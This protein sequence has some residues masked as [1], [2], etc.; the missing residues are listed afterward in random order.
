MF[1]RIGRSDTLRHEVVEYIR[2]LIEEGKLKPGDRLP[3][4]R[5]MAEKFGVSRTVI[6]DAVKTLTGLGVLEVK[7]GIGIFAAVPDSQSIARQ[8]SGLLFYRE[9]TIN[10]LFEVRMLLETEAAGWAAER[11]NREDLELL[12]E[13][14]RSHKSIAESGDVKTMG[15]LDR[16]F[17]ILVANATGNPVIIRLMKNLLD[18]FMVSNQQTLTIT[19]RALQSVEEH[20]QICA[21]IKKKDVAKA[22]L[23]MTKHLTSVVES[24]S[25]L[26]E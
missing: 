26:N 1:Q 16:S 3:T 24:L 8:L 20:R 11:R 21:A 4:E 2:K 5:E 6:R 22:R 18:L 23:A 7:H 25:E 14:A 12:F 9:D 17:H 13:N 10:N 15:E 19:G